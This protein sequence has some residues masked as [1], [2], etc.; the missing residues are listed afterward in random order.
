MLLAAGGWAVTR[1]RRRRRRESE[2]APAA[3]AAPPVERWIAAGEA[4]AVA[5]VVADRLRNRIAELAPEA[6]R[7]LSAEECIGVLERRR[8]DWPLRDLSDA[9]RALERARFAPAVPG[10]VAALVRQVGALLQ[11]LPEKSAS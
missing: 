8:P 3:P 11:A 6:D 10:D 9:L 2:A 1:R 7:A 5:A 4:R